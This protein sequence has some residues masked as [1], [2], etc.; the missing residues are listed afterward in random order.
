MTAFPL[1]TFL[2][3]T[4]PPK[5]QHSCLWESYCSLG[6]TWQLCGG[7]HLASVCSTRT[8]PPTHTL[9]LQIKTPFSPFPLLPAGS[10]SLQHVM[11]KVS[12]SEIPGWAFTHSLLCLCW[13]FSAHQVWLR[14]LLNTNP[15]ILWP[16]TYTEVM[17]GCNVFSY[18]EEMR[19]GGCALVCPA[20]PENSLVFL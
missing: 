10:Q 8:N 19:S 9:L 1:Q 16:V 12:T 18:T 5:L 11:L 6:G 14:R 4:C 20:A 15:S 17:L 3:S 7:R 13:Y 2:P